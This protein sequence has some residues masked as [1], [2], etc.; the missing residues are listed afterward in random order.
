MYYAAFTTLL[1]FWRTVKSARQNGG[2]VLVSDTYT[3]VRGTEISGTDLIWTGPNPDLSPEGFGACI[4]FIYHVSVYTNHPING[5]PGACADVGW[6]VSR[7]V[8]S[9]S[10]LRCV[11]LYFVNDCSRSYR[12]VD[13]SPRILRCTLNLIFGL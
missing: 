2:S 5:R 1:M 9:R 3:S 11:A 7:A 12:S 13:L 6:H 10:C 8:R 4:F